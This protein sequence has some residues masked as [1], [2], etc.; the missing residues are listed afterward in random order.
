M[1]FVWFV[2]AAVAEI[3]GCFTFWMWLRL[4]RSA[5]WLVPGIA[6]LCLFAFFL[7]RADAQFAGRA[8]AAYG[9][10]Y[11]AASLAWMGIVEHRTPQVFDVAGALVCIG[12][13]AL[14]LY[15]GQRLG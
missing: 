1:S 7:T 13:A 4:D 5:W 14:I 3:F 9:G 8:F 2:L 12:G 6:S 10:V 15:G 11:I